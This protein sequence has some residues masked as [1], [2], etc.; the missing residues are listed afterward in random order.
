MQSLLLL[1]ACGVPVVGAFM[2]SSGMFTIDEVIYLFSAEAMANRGSLTVDNGYGTFG[3]EDLRIWFLVDGPNGLAPQYPPGTAVLGAPFYLAFGDRGLIV[4][5]A[6]AAVGVVLTTWALAYRL[7]GDRAV[8]LLS[9]LVLVFGSFFLDYAWGIWPH[10]T[11]AFFVLLAFLL[12]LKAID[13]AR[14]GHV[15][16]LAAGSGLAVGAGFLMR[17]DAVLILPVIAACILLYAG[18]PILTLTGGVLG[19]LPGLAFLAVANLQ[20][21]GTLN[22]LSY[23]R[24]GGGGGDDIGSHAFAAMIFLVALLGAAAVRIGSSS[25]RSRVAVAAIGAVAVGAV[26]AVPGMFEQVGLVGRGYQGL[27]LDAR[28]LIETRPG[29]GFADDGTLVFWGVAKK[30]VVQSLPW[31][32]VLTVLL[33]RDWRAPFRRPTVVL[34]FFILF[35]SL[36]FAALSWHGGYSSSMRYFLPILPAFAILGAASV[37][38][39]AA[40]TRRP[41]PLLLGGAIV[42]LFT[43]GWLFVS[44]QVSAGLSQQGLNLLAFFVI[45]GAVAAAA[46]GARARINAAPI[47]VTVVGIGLGAAFFGS[48]VVDVSYSQLVRN[49][50]AEASAAASQVEGPAMFYGSAKLSAFAVTRDDALLGMPGRTTNEV[51]PALFEDLLQEGYRVFATHRNAVTASERADLGFIPAPLFPNGPFVEVVAAQDAKTAM[52]RDA[53]L[54]PTMCSCC[55]LA[56]YNRDPRSLVDRLR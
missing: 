43:S 50:S 15:L 52:P 35:W 30:A 33:F 6:V 16:A 2:V 1:L 19:L 9:V 54:C 32:G 5:N 42:G 14:A 28:T 36:P 18:R 17:A 7:Y 49:R 12:A 47:A 11:S 48:V 37:V 45:A 24:S 41:G 29:T 13:E 27:F 4:L 34:L 56:E 44:G 46:V 39:L 22:V 10:M 26:F 53:V 8:A 51:N 21:F 38:D 3:A 25:G 55:H 23:G 31:L 20:K 40:R